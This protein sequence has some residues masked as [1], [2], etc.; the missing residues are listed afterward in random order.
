MRY[1]TTPKHCRAS[2][3]L[4]AQLYFLSLRGDSDHRGPDFAPLLHLQT[5]KA[6]FS[7]HNQAKLQGALYWLCVVLWWQ[8]RLHIHMNVPVRLQQVFEQFGFSLFLTIATSLQGRH[9]VNQLWL[10]RA[11]AFDNILRKD[12]FR[13]CCC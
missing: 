7:S 11:W 4:E 6:K 12:H 10:N 1:I 8:G 13:N 3:H 5:L 2:L 9:V